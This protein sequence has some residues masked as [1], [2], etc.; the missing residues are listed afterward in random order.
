[1]SHTAQMLAVKPETLFWRLHDAGPHH[2][3]LKFRA[4]QPASGRPVLQSRSHV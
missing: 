2:E 4:S 1:M 3:M